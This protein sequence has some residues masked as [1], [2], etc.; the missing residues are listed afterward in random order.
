[1]VRRFSTQLAE[2]VIPLMV[3]DPQQLPS[4]FPPQALLSR[5]KG[6]VCRREGCS[7]YLGVKHRMWVTKG[8]FFKPTS[9]QSTMCA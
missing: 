9:F 6:A 4:P 1:M 2:P 3:C 8:E 5:G 7:D